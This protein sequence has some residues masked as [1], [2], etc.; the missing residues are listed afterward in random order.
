MN[1]NKEILDNLSENEF[2]EA[3]L[4][5]PSVV[6]DEILKIISNTLNKT[7]KYYFSLSKLG[8]FW[9]V[10]SRNGIPKDKIRKSAFE[11]IT[12]NI[13][14]SKEKFYSFLTSSSA[15]EH[16]DQD[17]KNKLMISE[18]ECSNKLQELFDI[19]L[20][21]ECICNYYKE[22]IAKL[23]DEIKSLKSEV[24]TKEKNNKKINIQKIKTT[25]KNFIAEEIN[26]SY[27]QT[28]EDFIQKFKDNNE[29]IVDLIND[30]KYTEIYDYILLNYVL[31][32]E[33]KS[34]NE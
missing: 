4:I 32:K 1:I 19:D 23:E 6:T 29:K 30:N 11:I 20:D 22:K 33:L 10:Y 24:E 3:I 5:L 15:T 25:K 17:L 16:L 28:K 34:E 12:K 21:K 18:L 9:S 7:D 27:L 13:D 26:E 14:K 2:L 8:L 31:V